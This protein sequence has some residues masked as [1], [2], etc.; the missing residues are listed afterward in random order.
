MLP[1]NY[2]YAFTTS[3]NSSSSGNLGK[4]TQPAAKPARLGRIYHTPTAASNAGCRLRQTVNIAPVIH[5]NFIFP[6]SL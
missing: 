4:Q 6:L 5:L 2:V 3:T 1:M